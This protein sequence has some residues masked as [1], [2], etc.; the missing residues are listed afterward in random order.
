MHTHIALKSV[1]DELLKLRPEITP[2]DLRVIAYLKYPMRDIETRQ[3]LLPSV[4]LAQ[5]YDSERQHK[6]NNFEAKNT[7]E[8]EFT[9]HTGIKVSFAMPSGNGEAQGD[10]WKGS[11][12]LCRVISALEIPNDI[13]SLWD[14]LNGANFGD[15][16]TVYLDTGTAAISRNRTRLMK[17]LEREAMEKTEAAPNEITKR[18]LIYMN[19][20]NSCRFSELVKNLPKV[21]AEAEKLR[22]YAREQQEHAIMS[23]GACPKPFYHSLAHGPRIAQTGSGLLGFKREYRPIIAPDWIELDLKSAQAAFIAKEWGDTPILES[24]LERGLDDSEFSLWAHLFNSMGLKSNDAMKRMMKDAFYGIMYGAGKAKIAETFDKKIGR[25]ELADAFFGLPL[26]E[27]IVSRRKK[28]VK[29]LI[30]KKEV[31]DCLGMTYRVPNGK[32]ALS[33]LA[34]MSQSWEMKLLEGC[35][36]MA[37][38]ESEKKNP[39]FAIALSQHDGFSL[40][41]IRKRDEG[42]WSREMNASVVRIAKEHGILTRLEI[43]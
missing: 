6:S 33:V 23:F 2:C 19:S 34:S 29:W 10:D 41:S 4:I 5:C 37:I 20:L 14:A 3:P 25:P 26:I 15:E 13:Q 17:R 42:R 27:E 7:L 21:R 1:R 11:E 40:A 8:R 16:G 22:G 9:R 28:R 31:T 24:L 30:E 18:V 32:R 38:E 43:S 36:D 12:G 39:R 35:Y